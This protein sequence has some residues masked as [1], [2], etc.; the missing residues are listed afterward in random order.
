M[1]GDPYKG[2]LGL[3]RDGKGWDHKETGLS[4]VPQPMILDFLNQGDKV[5]KVICGGIHTALLTEFGKAYTSGCGSDG[6]LG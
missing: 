4:P 5:A 1:W 2:Q 6:R 3:Y